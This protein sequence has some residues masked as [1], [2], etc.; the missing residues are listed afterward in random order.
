M[1]K[2]VLNIEKLFTGET[3]NAL[4]LD[5][6]DEK[7]PLLVPPLVGGTPEEKQEFVSKWKSI[8][9]EF[10][11]PESGD[12]A[13]NQYILDFNLKIQADFKK[14]GRQELY[15]MDDTH[16][17]RPSEDTLTSG[18]L[19]L[20]GLNGKLEDNNTQEDDMV[21]SSQMSVLFPFKKLS[22][23]SLYSQRLKI[24]STR[25]ED[26]RMEESR[27][28]TIQGKV[29]SQD[30]LCGSAVVG[31]NMYALSP[32]ADTIASGLVGN[33]MTILNRYDH[34]P[35]SFSNTMTLFQ[36]SRSRYESGVADFV[37]WYRSHCH[38]TLVRTPR[39]YGGNESQLTWIGQGS[40]DLQ[41]A[42][43]GPT[44]IVMYHGDL[45]SDLV[46]E[47]SLNSDTWR[48]ARSGR[49]T[50]CQYNGDGQYV[51][52]A[53][54]ARQLEESLFVG[55]KFNLYDNFVSGQARL[56]DVVVPQNTDYDN[57]MLKFKCKV[58]RDPKLSGDMTAIVYA[59]EWMDEAFEAT[60]NDKTSG[61]STSSRLPEPEADEPNCRRK[62]V[63][64]PITLA[65]KGS[66]V[67]QVRVV[68]Q[69]QVDFSKRRQ[70]REYQDA[71]K[72][73]YVEL[74]DVDVVPMGVRPHQLKDRELTFADY[75]NEAG[76]AEDER[77]RRYDMF[78]T[79]SVYKSNIPYQGVLETPLRNIVGAGLEFPNN[80]ST[81]DMYA[82]MFS[83]K[84]VLNPLYDMQLKAGKWSMSRGCWVDEDTKDDEAVDALRVVGRRYIDIG[85]CSSQL[86]LK[87]LPTEVV[88]L[89]DGSLVKASQVNFNDLNYQMVEVVRNINKFE[90]SIKHKSN[91]FS[92]VVENSNLAKDPTVD[93]TDET[94]SEFQLEKYKETLRNS[95][96]QFVRNACAGITPVHTQLFDV[97]F[98]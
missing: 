97:Q 70:E 17:M 42:M 80:Y 98:R 82:D 81:G 92:V 38:K 18:K 31:D 63:A 26:E 67:V 36:P 32:F 87:Y 88:A 54:N 11:P 94:S 21:Y 89:D 8:Y 9:P 39:E 57:L 74:I 58:R 33:G 77:K 50:I 64:I 91:V 95:V 59:P 83:T 71:L 30:C 7:L 20:H 19:H 56:I 5:R 28:I 72:N 90:S 84:S 61:T 62:S 68:V 22:G 53:D 12:D 48:E 51:V 85:Q 79:P 6:V 55:F 34:E 37:H 15:M 2:Y 25:D 60:L 76:I 78:W 96:S 65:S 47:V 44:S 13:I 41:L 86:Y 45:Y 14:R 27:L 73:S 1:K 3:A 66:H 23:K 29:T 40:Y 75:V 24:G 93:M 4:V 49:N 16:Q 52:G 69:F 35:F 46:D 10:N 43:H